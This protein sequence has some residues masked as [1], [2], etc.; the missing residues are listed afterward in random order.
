MTSTLVP[1]VRS[2]WINGVCNKV[3]DAATSA[4][5][6]PGQFLFIWARVGI[7]GKESPDILE[8]YVLTLI[9]D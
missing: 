2:G 6:L 3:R 9:K 4:L 8:W 7:D 5:I 1:T